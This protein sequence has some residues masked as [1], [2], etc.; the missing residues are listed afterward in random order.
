MEY[1]IIGLVIA[2]A[3]LLLIVIILSNKLNK[4][5]NKNNKLVEINSNLKEENTYKENELNRYKEQVSIYEKDELSR[6]IIFLDDKE[7]KK[8]FLFKSKKVIIGD[9]MEETALNTMKILQSFGIT[10]DV[11]RSGKDIVDRIQHGYKYDLIFTNNV[12]EN[13]GSGSK[14]L[15]ELKSIKGF[16]TPVIIHTVSGNQ[17]D[18]FINECHFDEY[19]T[20]PVTQDNLK[21]IL[22]KFLKQRRKKNER[23]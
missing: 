16:K 8:N 7:I 21:P 17:R 3:L 11:V 23:R 5:K 14:T 15:M 2:T 19:I 20:K 13:G 4:V 1:L 18:Y 10:V 22:E 12:Y 6:K 9:Y